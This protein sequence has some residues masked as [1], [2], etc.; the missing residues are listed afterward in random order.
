MSVT[1]SPENHPFL[2]QRPS[3]TTPTR[4]DC[5]AGFGL[6]TARRVR[7]ITSPYQGEKTSELMI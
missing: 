4:S 5:I 3:L 6:L 1:C 2:R 7:D